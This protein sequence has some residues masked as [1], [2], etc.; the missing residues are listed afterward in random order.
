MND[1]VEQGGRWAGEDEMEVACRLLCRVGP[2][3]LGGGCK[4]KSMDHL[5]EKRPFHVTAV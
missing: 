1:S 4:K 5:Y 3:R 2:L